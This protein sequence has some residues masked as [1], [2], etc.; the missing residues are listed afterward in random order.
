MIIPELGSPNLQMMWT[1]AFVA[2]PTEGFGLK[3]ALSL[4]LT[5]VSDIPDVVESGRDQKNFSTVTNSSPVNHVEFKYTTELNFL[6]FGI[7]W[8]SLSLYRTVLKKLALIALSQ[9]HRSQEAF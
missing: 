2:H 9:S 3:S 5:E 4:A 8:F 6:R 1:P 7:Q